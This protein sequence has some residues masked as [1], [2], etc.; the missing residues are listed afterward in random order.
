MTNA[1]MPRVAICMSG[2]MRG[3]AKLAS[4]QIRRLVGPNK[5][6]LF[7]C[8][9]DPIKEQEIREAYHKHL[10]GLVF[11]TGHPIAEKE[12]F[13]DNP[14]WSLFRLTQRYYRGKICYNQMLK[15]A[16]VNKITYD[17]IVFMRPDMTLTKRL[18]VLS[19]NIEKNAVYMLGG[20]FLKKETDGTITRLNSVWD[21]FAIGSLYSIGMING[22]VE[23]FDKYRTK[24]MWSNYS[25]KRGAN[26]E[27]QLVLHL[28]K[29]HVKIKPLAKKYRFYVLRDGSSGKRK[30]IQG[31]RWA[32]KYFWDEYPEEIPMYLDQI[33]KSGERLRMKRLRKKRE[34]TEAIRAERRKK[35]KKERKKRKDVRRRK[36]V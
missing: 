35:I 14:G 5:A 17:A 30:D 8:G 1:R 4:L 27:A 23:N 26:P 6:D 31:F 21:G 18:D 7:I 13:A 32:P 25:R 20:I 24:E 15:Y 34:R 10:K 36:D 9:D 19:L 28:H 3:F 12:G 2:Q 16:K 29:N 11:T 22:L 33:V